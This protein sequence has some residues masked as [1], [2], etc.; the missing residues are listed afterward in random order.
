MPSLACSS[1]GPTSDPMEGWVLG[2]AAEGTKVLAEGAGGTASG[3]KGLFINAHAAM[4]KLAGAQVPGGL[5]GATSPTFLWLGEAFLELPSGF[6]PASPLRGTTL[7]WLMPL[8]PS[9]VPAGLYGYHVPVCAFLGLEVPAASLR[10][11]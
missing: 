3:P 7:A 6:L 1:Q 11:K 5:P 9:C 4:F 2:R 10:A 8:L